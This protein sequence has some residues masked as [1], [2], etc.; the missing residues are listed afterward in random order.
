MDTYHDANGFRYRVSYMGESA[1]L[2]TILGPDGS[3]LSDAELEGFLNAFADGRS[4]HEAGTFP[5]GGKVWQRDDAAVAKYS[6]GGKHSAL[7]FMT[8]KTLKLFM[9]NE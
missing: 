7:E 9:V 3:P 4:W 1:E 2:V 8:T 5:D 6:T